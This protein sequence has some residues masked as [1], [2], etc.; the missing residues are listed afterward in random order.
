MLNNVKKLSLRICGG[1]NVQ[2]IC[3]SGVA[4]KL[5]VFPLKYY[6]QFNFGL[7]MCLRITFWLAIIKLIILTVLHSYNLIHFS[8]KR[9]QCIKD[10]N[11]NRQ[12]MLV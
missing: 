8:V 3:V 1:S 9:Q 12:Y 4:Q 6:F 7:M 10:C 5:C 2:S 11:N